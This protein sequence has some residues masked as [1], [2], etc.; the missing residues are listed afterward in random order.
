MLKNQSS[1]KNVEK[2]PKF[3]FIRRDLKTEDAPR[4][5]LSRRLGGWS[6]LSV[7]SPLALIYSPVEETLKIQPLFPEAIPIST[8]IANKLRGTKSSCF[9]TLPG[10]GK[11]P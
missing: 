2:L 9:S 4:G 8:D 5:A 1:R 7:P 10:W 6:H 3:L 11:C